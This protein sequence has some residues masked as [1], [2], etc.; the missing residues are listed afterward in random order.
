M[1]KGTALNKRVWTLFENAGFQTEPNSKDGKEHLVQL[2][3]SKKIPVDLYARDSDLK[4]TILGSNKSGIRKRWTEHV[5][6]YITLGQKA[7][8][9]RVLFVITGSELDAPDRDHVAQMDAVLWTE[10]ELSYYEAVVEAIG[11][12][13]KYE[14][15][16]ALNIQTAEERMTVKVLALRLHQPKADSETAMFLFTMCPEWL[17]KLCVIYRRAIGSAGAYQ[18]MLRVKRLP[19]IKKFH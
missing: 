14:I 8:A 13:A 11:H 18:R 6:N 10:E 15:I 17:L 2:T 4:V 1:D 7:K 19:K 12:Y 16:R 5:S 3:A 9:N